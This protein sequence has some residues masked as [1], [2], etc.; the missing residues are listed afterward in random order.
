MVSEPVGL[1]T[2]RQVRAAAA[3]HARRQPVYR[4]QALA[5]ARARH[6]SPAGEGFGRLVWLTA[7]GAAVPGASLVAAG[8]RLVGGLLVAGFVGLLLLTALVVVSGEA[9]S[10]GLG[11][12]TRPNALL[13][14]AVAVVG[15]AIVWCAAIL[16]GHVSL[17]RT[18]LTTD[19]RVLSAVLVAALMGLVALPSA[20]A[21]R[22]ALA[23]RSLILTVFDDPGEG[24]EGGLAAPDL[25]AEDPWEDHPRINV[26]LLGSDAGAGRTGTR[27]D[28]MIVAS[29][30]TRSG[31][32]VLFSLPRNLEGPIFAD[33]S[34]GDEQFPRGF[35]PSGAGACVQN[36]CHLN[37]VWTWAENNPQ[38]YAGTDEPGLQATR[39]AIAGVLGLQLDYYAIVNLD[40]FTDLVNAIGGVEMTVERR[41]PIGGGTNQVTGGRNPVTGYIEPGRQTLDGYN[42]L[43][44]ARS[45]E[46]S[47]D[48][49]RM[50]RQRC[51]LAAVAEQAQPGRLARAFPALAASAERNIVTD[52]RAGEL[53]AFVEL[54][55]RVQDASIR[56]LSFD[57]DVITPED[58]DFDAIH[59]F[60]QE[61][62]DPEATS[63]PR[64]G[65][66]TPTAT[67][68]ATPTQAATQA[69]ARTATRAPAATEDTPSPTRTSEPEEAV[70]VK[71]VCGVPAG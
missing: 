34:P 23:Q 42:A 52:V 57:R 66:T 59:A 6:A 65:T 9:V 16:V 38:V 24:R 22:Y 64:P 17:R 13:A 33:G 8:R 39:D 63:T 68:S 5:V 44:Y 14:V 28:T 43:W 32:T 2:R 30:D 15:G 1:P 69:P 40:G 55:L 58:P 60:V 4:R 70:D 61:A 20:T 48:Y 54:A 41:I 56:S 36:D 35:H 47:T 53:E 11:L 10:L 46:G 12:A 45:R 49:D 62:I 51:V 21:A 27:T 25:E 19:Q 18:R 67:P 71:D 31:E 29:I 7:L 50:A 26:L 3:R 37:A